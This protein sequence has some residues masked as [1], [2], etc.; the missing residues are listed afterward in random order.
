MIVHQVLPDG[1][2]VT[3]LAKPEAT[4][5]AKATAVPKALV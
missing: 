1:L 4:H 2:D 5:A 3:A